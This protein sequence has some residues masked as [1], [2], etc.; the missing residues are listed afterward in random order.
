MGALAKGLASGAVAA[1]QTFS[2]L[3]LFFEAYF[4]C[5]ACCVEPTAMGRRR[6]GG[7][8]DSLPTH[9]LGVPDL[10][11]PGLCYSIDV[12]YLYGRRMVERVATGCQGPAAP[13][14][15]CRRA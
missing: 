6:C 14:G 1:A 8:N 15:W 12:H 3:F 11:Q 13:G 7:R 10:Q 4:S 5:T 2:S 9:L